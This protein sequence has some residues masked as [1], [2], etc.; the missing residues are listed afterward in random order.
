MAALVLCAMAVS[1]FGGRG[2]QAVQYGSVAQPGSA[3]AGASGQRDTYAVRSGDTLARIAHRYKT[4]ASVLAGM[5]EIKNPD[6][7]LVGQV[8]EVPAQGEQAQPVAARGP[9]EAGSGQ[10]S[11]SSSSPQCYGMRAR[12]SAYNSLP[13]QT[14]GDPFLTASGFYLKDTD[15]NLRPEAYVAA[16]RDIPFWSRVHVPGYGWATVVDRGSAV[17]RGR[18]D[19]WMHRKADAN[20]WGVAYPTVT[21]CPHS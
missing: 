3:L 18:I 12:V 8:L 20:E 4:T 17:T 2:A 5:N 9:A 19:L 14:W 16:A 21:V 10:A 15:G 13:E 7:I 11:G 1:A 6:L